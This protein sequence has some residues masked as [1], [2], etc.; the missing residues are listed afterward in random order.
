MIEIF[1]RAAALVLICFGG[2]LVIWPGGKLLVVELVDIRKDYEKIFLH[3]ESQNL[4]GGAVLL[5]GNKD[6]PPFR[7]YENSKTGRNRITASG[8]AWSELIAALN[9]PEKHPELTNKSFGPGER[10]FVF[11]PED[12]PFSELAPFPAEAVHIPAG[13]GRWLRIRADHAG[14]IYALPDRYLHPYTLYGSILIVLGFVLYF[15]I[16]HRKF[17][18]DEIH[19]P[20]GEAVI[21]PDM[22]GLILGPVF[23]LLPFMIVWEMDSEMSVFDI[24]G[25]WIWL[26]V[27]MWLLAS[28][29]IVL[30]CAACRYSLLC[31]RVTKDGFHEIKG[32]KETLFRWQDIEFYRHYRT[33]LSSGLSTLLLIFGN[34]L[35]AAAAGIMLRGREEFGIRVHERGGR[36]IKIMGNS[37]PE[38]DDIIRAMREHGIKCRPNKKSG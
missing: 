13:D 1:R 3:K 25:G 37:L 16:P 2:Y 32:A 23:F 6:I 22:L 21:A 14:E 28:L 26:T 33:R 24:S 38:F 31:Y 17:T 27:A 35:Q 34:T 10:R 30:L 36:S 7:E 15:I 8:P 5:K 12:R 29:W 18:E 20:R 9:E 11:S 19:Y 4:P